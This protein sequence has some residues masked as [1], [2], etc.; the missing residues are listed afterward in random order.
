MSP[1]AL[2]SYKIDYT[3]AHSRSAAEMLSTSIALRKTL[4]GSQLFYLSQPRRSRDGE[5]KRFAVIVKLDVV[6]TAALSLAC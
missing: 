5:L 3:V 4:R 2:G 1:E 6:L